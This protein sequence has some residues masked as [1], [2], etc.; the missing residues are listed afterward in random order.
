MDCIEW[1][2]LD[3]RTI[4]KAPIIT[5]FLP[6]VLHHTGHRTILNTI[7]CIIASCLIA[8]SGT[9]HKCNLMY[10]VS[11]FHAH[12][13]CNFIRNRRAADRTCIY[14]CFSFYDC[15]CKP[16]TSCISAAAAVISGKHAANRF[17]SGI[18][19]YCKFFSCHAKEDADE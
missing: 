7:I 2:C 11:C 19:F 1:T 5:G 10:G 14:R 3:T 12:D 6:A 18:R 16:Q 17:L 13:C 8:C 4:S 15:G 9:L